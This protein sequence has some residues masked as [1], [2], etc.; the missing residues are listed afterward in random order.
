MRRAQ[1]ARMRKWL[2]LILPL[3][4]LSVHAQPLQNIQILKGLSRPEIQRVMNEMRA[5]LGVHCHFCHGADDTHGASDVKPQKAKAREMIRMVMDLNARHF[6]GKPVVTCFTCHNGH[7][8]PATIPPL[9]Q[10]VP[11]EPA[12]VEAKTYPSAASIIQKYVAAVGREITPSTSRVLKGTHKSP[13]GPQVKIAVSD[14]GEKLRGDIQLPDGTLLS[15]AYD[16]TAG[17]IR[18]KNGVRDMEP[19]DLVNARMSRRAFAPFFTSSIGNDARVIDSEKIGDHNAWIVETPN[20]RYWFDTET[21]LL[22]RR[23]AYFNSPV[24]RIPEETD[25]DDYRD[26]GGQKLPFLI[27]VALVDPW[28]GGTRQWESIQV[29]AAIAPA[30]FEKPQG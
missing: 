15:Q 30:E 25:F 20:A 1:N 29:G 22:L 24:G 26:T 3:F 16:G 5:G 6:G 8:R 9:P 10:A 18:D 23:V 2:I 27:R 7:P 4:A 19:D 21:G 28:S 17:W 14:N 13:N 11:P 12:A